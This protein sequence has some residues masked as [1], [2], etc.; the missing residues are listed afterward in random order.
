ML[1][2]KLVSHDFYCYAYCA[3]FY[4]VNT[5]SCGSFSDPEAT[6]H[7]MALNAYA[8][9]LEQGSHIQAAC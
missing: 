2:V 1:V 6:W 7:S 8:L 3:G 9:S 4:T 5:M